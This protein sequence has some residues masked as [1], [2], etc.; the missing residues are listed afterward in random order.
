MDSTSPWEHEGTL[1][2]RT[3][4]TQARGFCL[5]L[6]VNNAVG[7]TLVSPQQLLQ[8]RTEAHADP[9]APHPESPCNPDGWFADSDFNFWAHRNR[10]HLLLLNIGQHSPGC[11][12][13]T[14]LSHAILCRATRYS[15]PQA[16]CS[17]PDYAIIHQPAGHFVAVV[18]EPQ[19]KQW[20]VIDPTKWDHQHNIPCCMAMNNSRVRD[21]YTGTIYLFDNPHCVRQGCHLR[22]H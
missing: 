19:T 12:W 18:R 5:P 4:E 2:V 8:S 14:S 10:L 22:E 6:A 13:E 3:F 16:Q 17:E 15:Q 21:T 11:R 7:S 1:S 20:Y 9:L